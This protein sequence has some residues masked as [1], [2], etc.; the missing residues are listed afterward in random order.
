MLS[1][2][3]SWL[4]VTWQ[5][6]NESYTD[7]PMF[8]SDL[9]VRYE[10]V[11]ELSSKMETVADWKEAYKKGVI[12]YLEDKRVRGSCCGN[13]VGHC[14]AATDLL[15]QPG[16]FTSQGC[17]RKVVA[18]ELP[19]SRMQGWRRFCLEYRSQMKVGSFAMVSNVQ[20][21]IPRI[22]CSSGFPPLRAW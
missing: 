10:A 9:F 12:Y 17:L 19:D 16:P 3:A 11:G 6:A 4:V 21:M 13:V 7:V 22:R 1:E 14:P 8:Y 18:Q 2:W 15:A 5:G 20:V